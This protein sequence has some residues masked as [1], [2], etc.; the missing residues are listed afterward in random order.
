[1]ILFILRNRQ[2]HRDWLE[3]SDTK[4]PV[5]LRILSQNQKDI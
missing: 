3:D 2:L 5:G 1:M 4:Q